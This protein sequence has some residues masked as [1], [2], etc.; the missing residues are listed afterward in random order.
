MSPEALG[1]SHQGERNILVRLC[2]LRLILAL[3][4]ETPVNTSHERSTNEEHQEQKEGGG[5][6]DKMAVCLSVAVPVRLC[7][8]VCLS[9]GLYGLRGGGGEE[10]TCRVSR[11]AAAGS[12]SGRP[13]GSPPPS[14]GSASGAPTSS[15]GPLRGS[16][17]APQHPE[18][19]RREG[20]EMERGRGPERR[21]G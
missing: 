9:V 5:G 19:R 13:P 15:P 16:R 20:R 10:P 6:S 18:E 1:C 2:D 11:A 7:V 21:E 17:S 3:V 8:C 14:S 12:C 4:D